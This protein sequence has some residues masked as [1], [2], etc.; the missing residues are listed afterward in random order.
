[1][2]RWHGSMNKATVLPSRNMKFCAAAECVPKTPAL[3]RRPNHHELV[4]KGV[5]KIAQEEKVVGWQ[6]G[7]PSGARFRVYE[8]LKNFVDQNQ[9]TLFVTPIC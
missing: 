1:M 2:M 7:R 9:G 4:R 8:R 3:P 5:E 6:L